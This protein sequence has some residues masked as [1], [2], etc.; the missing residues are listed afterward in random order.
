MRL[1]DTDMILSVN[2]HRVIDKHFGRQ[3]AQKELKILE[4]LLSDLGL[5]IHSASLATELHRKSAT[6][7]L[8]IETLQNSTATTLF[9]FSQKE[10]LK[11]VGNVAKS[12]DFK[13]VV[14]KTKHDSKNEGNKDDDSK[15]KDKG[16]K[17]STDK[18]DKT[19]DDDGATE[20]QN[21]E[22]DSTPSQADRSNDTVQPST[23]PEVTLGITATVNVKVEH[24]K[25]VK[26]E[27]T[28]KESAKKKAEYELDPGGFVLGILG[29]GLKEGAEVV[30]KGI[31][32]I[33]GEDGERIDKDL[34]VGKIKRVAGDLATVVKDNKARV[35]QNPETGSS[36]VEE[37]QNE[38]LTASKTQIEKFVDELVNA[39]VGPQAAEVKKAVAEYMDLLT[40]RNHDKMQYNMCL[41]Q[42]V[43][44]R[45]KLHNLDNKHT[46]AQNELD[47]DP[48][49]QQLGQFSQLVE[50]V[51]TWSRVRTMRLISLYRRAIHFSELGDPQIHEAGS[52]ISDAALTLPALKIRSMQQN[53][54][55]QLFELQERAGSDPSRFPPDFDHDRGR[56]ADLTN[57]QLDFLLKDGEVRVTLPAPSSVNS[58]LPDFRGRANVRAYRVR[59]WLEGLRI[60][61]KVAEL[62]TLSSPM[63]ETASFTTP[64]EVLTSS[65]MILCPWWMVI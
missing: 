37:K 43:E 57:E 56:F 27:P 23:S 26:K 51:Y 50:E 55:S 47:N 62:S 19:K 18:E 49:A 33:P 5:R 46:E 52:R 22:T 34:M 3:N 36:E 14:K 15:G 25:D 53:L 6:L 64:K 61:Q 63:R 41:K 60:Q 35:K 31:T 10:I 24:V 39:N 20:N 2:S 44:S 16:N 45:T 38:L 32:T 12:V 1:D 59:F 8:E 13:T 42:L 58:E 48:N 9:D 4:T 11:S 17:E 28:K 30:W 65:P 7:A 29:S 54:N 40:S 21:D